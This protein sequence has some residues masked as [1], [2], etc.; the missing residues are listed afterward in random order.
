MVARTL[1]RRR[2]AGH[3]LARNDR[4]GARAMTI[5]HS[6]YLVAIE[7]GEQYGPLDRTSFHGPFLNMR[8]AEQYACR[9][10]ADFQRQYG[11]ARA[12][13]WPLVI[14]FSQK[15]TIEER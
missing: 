11:M 5:L 1:V 12:T 8:R 9:A 7:Y 14:P 15:V 3:D 10:A 2:D 4:S 6:G 13:V